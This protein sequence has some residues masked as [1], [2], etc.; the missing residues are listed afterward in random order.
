MASANGT[1]AGNPA[2]WASVVVGLL[3]VA[4]LPVAVAVARETTLFELIEAAAAI[5]VAAVG[6]IAAVVLGRRARRRVE[7]T[8]GRVGGAGRALLGRLLGALALCLA[9][10][11]TIAVGVYL[12]LS[13]FSE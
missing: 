8:I 10:S 2:A 7:R 12:F 1:P 9:S 6:G 5:P 4:A 13:R 11:A 3:A